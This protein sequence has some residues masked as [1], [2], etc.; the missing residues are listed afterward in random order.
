MKSCYFMPLEEVG[1]H[2][3]RWPPERCPGTEGQGHLDPRAWVVF[4]N[5]DG[6]WW[7][8]WQHQQGRE[9][10]VSIAHTGWCLISEPDS[11]AFVMSF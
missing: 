6:A 9:E 11:P 7:W 8:Y 1:A 4:H 5:G 3:T 2:D 10:T